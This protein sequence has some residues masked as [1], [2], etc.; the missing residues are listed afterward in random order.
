M[1]NYFSH[2]VTDEAT[3]VLDSDD[4]NREVFLQIIGNSTVYLGDNDSVTTANGFPV[5]KHTNAIRGVLGSGQEL[6]AIVA[7]GTEDL[8]VFTS[9]D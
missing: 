7:S 1:A 5:V 4:L 6:W 8:R 9:V 3:K 2:T